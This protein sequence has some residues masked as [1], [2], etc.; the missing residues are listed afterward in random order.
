MPKHQYTTWGPCNQTRL[1]S[2]HALLSHLRDQNLHPPSLQM[3][4]HAC[5]N[6]GSLHAHTALALGCWDHISCQLGLHASTTPC[7]DPIYN[8]ICTDGMCSISRATPPLYGM[9]CIGLSCHPDCRY[10]QLF[11]LHGFPLAQLRKYLM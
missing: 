5:A 8:C 2:S 10:T 7:S 11:P 1:L 9:S 4:S 3:G 6:P